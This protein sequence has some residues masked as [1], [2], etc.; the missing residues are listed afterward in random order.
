MHCF[1]SLCLKCKSASIKGFAAELSKLRIVLGSVV[2]ENGQGDRMLLDTLEGDLN[3]QWWF[4][5]FWFFLWMYDFFS[6]FPF[7]FP[8]AYWGSWMHC[9]SWVLPMLE[10]CRGFPANYHHSFAHSKEVTEITKIGFGSWR[11]RKLQVP[12]LRKIGFIYSQL[13][14]RLISN[15]KYR[16]WVF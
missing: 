5:S 6:S 13:C 11:A 3:F 14:N 16:I 2:C 15:L 9:S 12:A 8:L 1:Q 10:M 7:P 4:T